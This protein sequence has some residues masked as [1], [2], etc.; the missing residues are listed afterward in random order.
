LREK[1]LHNL[2]FVVEVTDGKIFAMQDFS[3]LQAARKFSAKD[4]RF[5]VE[6][7]MLQGVEQLADAV[8]VTMG[9]K[10]CCCLFCTPQIFYFRRLAVYLLTIVIVMLC[11]FTHFG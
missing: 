8:Q 6:A 1:G 3:K 2:G 7:L 4:I 10:V 11:S 5:G 9:P